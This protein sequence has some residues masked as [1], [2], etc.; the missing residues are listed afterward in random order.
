VSALRTCY[1]PWYFKKHIENIEAIGVERDLAGLPV[2][3]VPAELLSPT[4]TAE[5]TAVFNAVRDIV[6]NIRRDAQEGIVWPSNRDEQGNQLYT[7]K[8]LSTGGTRQFDTS[9]I[10]QRYEQRIAMSVLADM[11]LLG[12]E[13]VGSYALSA[14]KTSMF[15][16]AM[17]AWLTSIAGVVNAHA[18]PRLLRLNG[19]DVALTPRLTFGAV[20]DVDIDTVITFVKDMTAAGMQFFPSPELENKLRGDVG[21]PPLSD[22]DMQRREQAEVA[23]EAA[24]QRAA[25]QPPAQPPTQE[26]AQ[27]Q[28]DEAPDARQMAAMLEAAQRVLMRGVYGD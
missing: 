2:A 5:Q 8:L 13:A 10:I 18:I 3:E 27:D 1:R 23:R 17:Q 20:G 9:A 21:L 26:P 24:R 16:T 19:M 14:T 15:K 11:I 7:L 22:E 28:E 4:L 6:V 12:H 25:E